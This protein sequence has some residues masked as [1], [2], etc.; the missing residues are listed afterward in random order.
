LFS[1]VFLAKIDL[2]HEMAHLNSK[3]EAFERDL[4][5]LSQEALQNEE[6]RKRLFGVVS[7][8]VAMLEAPI[9]TIWRMIMTVR[10][11]IFRWSSVQTQLY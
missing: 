7:R 4:Q 9:E 2:I 10:N 5:S 3:I 6:S 1:L 8:A 11:K